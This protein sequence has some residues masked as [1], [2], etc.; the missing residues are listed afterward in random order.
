M[1]QNKQRIDLHTHSN[2]SD[3]TDSPTQLMFNAKAAGL[4]VIALTDHDITGGWAEASQQVR[5]TG[6]S[7]VRGMELSCA[8]QGIT[9]HLL[10]Y[11]HQPD[12]APLQE[13]QDKTMKSRF[14][15]A[16]EMVERLSKDYGLT[17]EQVVAQAPSG[18][19]VGRPHIADA[20]V[21]NGLFPNRS[22]C[23]QQVLHPTS[24]YYVKHWSLDP[25]QAVELV[26]AAK[27]VPVIAHP[28][29][30]AR[31]KLLPTKVIIEMAKHGLAGIEVHHRDNSHADRN[32]LL[33]L[34]TAYDLLVTGSSDYHG[35]GKPNQLGENL[36]RPQ[37]LTA[38][39]QQ[40]ELEVLTP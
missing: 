34:A 27:G 12:S 4:D 6:V 29:A 5:N 3:G 37:V 15:R 16:Q 36:T 9:V 21:A 40:G 1:R 33:E 18:G 25:I 20:L 2:L 26:R 30:R 17:W 23:F 19:P 14:S 22:A 28:R 13:V 39:A 31:Q 32:F 10:C 8:W 38:I 35:S 7:L 11:L 24:P